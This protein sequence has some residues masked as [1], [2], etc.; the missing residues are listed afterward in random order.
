MC[1]DIRQRS[2]SLLSTSISAALTQAQGL[3]PNDSPSPAKIEELASALEAA[4]FSSRDQQTG[5]DYRNAIREKSLVLKKD[6]PNMVKALL[7]GE[8]SPQEFATAEASVRTVTARRHCIWQ[9]FWWFISRLSLCSLCVR[10]CMCYLL[11]VLADRT[12]ARPRNSRQTPCWRS[13]ISNPR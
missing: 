9:L 2:A 4:L 7:S 3:S 5:N 12:F 11:C 8:F 6:N 13:E 10:A 1:K